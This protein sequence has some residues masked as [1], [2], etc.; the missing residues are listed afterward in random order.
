MQVPEPQQ[1][2]SCMVNSSMVE[3]IQTKPNTGISSLDDVHLKDRTH[4]R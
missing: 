2:S 3:T 1:R 4:I